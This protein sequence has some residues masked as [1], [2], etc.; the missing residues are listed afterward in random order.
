MG[1]VLYGKWVLCTD[2]KGWWL[3]SPIYKADTAHMHL[4]ED[5]CMAS[6]LWFILNDAIEHE[7]RYPVKDLR[8]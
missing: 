3:H 7:R 1:P 5:S 2:G 4:G 8:G 6:T